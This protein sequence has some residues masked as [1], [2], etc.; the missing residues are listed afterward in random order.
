MSDILLSQGASTIAQLI[1][2]HFAN[3][4]A[5]II[6]LPAAGPS[7]DVCG[8]IEIRIQEEWK[9][10]VDHHTKPEA[11]CITPTRPHPS[12]ADWNPPKIEHPE[13]T[14]PP[15][16]PLRFPHPH[17]SPDVVQPENDEGGGL[18]PWLSNHWP[19]APGCSNS[20]PP[21]P[22]PPPSTPARPSW[23]LPSFP[24]RP[25]LPP[26]S[27]PLQP[28]QPVQA[29]TSSITFITATGTTGTTRTTT[30][31][32][33]TFVL[34][35]QPPLPTR[36]A[37]PPSPS[38]LAHPGGLGGNGGNSGDDGR[39]GFVTP[40]YIVRPPGGDGGNGGKGG[41]GGS[42]SLPLPPLP[43]RPVFSPPPVLPT[44]PISQPNN[45]EPPQTF[46]VSSSPLP[47]PSSV[48][49]GPSHLPP[50]SLPPVPAP[51]QSSIPVV[52]HPQAPTHSF[53][54]PPPRPTLPH[55]H[56]SSPPLPVA[57]PLPPFC[58]STYTSIDVSE[59]SGVNPHTYDNY[60]NLLGVAKPGHDLSLRGGV[61]GG[62]GKNRNN[63][64][65]VKSTHMHQYRVRCGLSLPPGPGPVFPSIP[66]GREHTIT[67]PNGH[68]GCLESCEREAIASADDGAL[69]ECLGVA[70]RAK[71][72]GIDGEGVCK[73]W[74][75]DRN[76]HHFL[77]VESL[78]NGGG[79]G[80]WQIIYM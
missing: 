77:P 24:P 54:L 71:L 11:I 28:P 73:F 62:G 4:G 33:T 46:K 66:G 65:E 32:I 61:F 55:A 36:P 42:G 47:P 63:I 20:W 29:A 59:I 50:F 34:P 10:F 74:A 1:V 30:H 68:R 44:R 52:A 40:G 75:G 6:D 21:R 49:H 72:E 15:S 53:D 43:T 48:F 80:R 8:S 38:P 51:T 69:D 45:T 16:F 37:L 19:A 78:P 13:P 17:P 22:R 39:E 5:C 2:Q 67:V 23:E 41:N 35:S 25:L 57:P 12:P 18:S 79:G 60:L 27:P 70:F 9:D 14:R 31:T 3:T 26:S 58:E 64:A 7:L 56:V 76:E